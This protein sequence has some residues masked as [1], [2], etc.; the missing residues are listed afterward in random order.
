LT[1]EKFKRLS[2]RKPL[3][4]T[5]FINSAQRKSKKFPLFGNVNFFRSVNSAGKEKPA[6]NNSYDNKNYRK[7][8]WSRASIRRAAFSEEKISRNGE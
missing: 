1:S 4:G 8:Q 5:D 2:N 3:S 6:E 7:Y